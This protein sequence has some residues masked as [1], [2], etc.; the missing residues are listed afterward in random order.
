[1]TTLQADLTSV[2]ALPPSLSPDEIAN[3]IN[4]MRRWAPFDGLG[5]DH[6]QWLA[7]RMEEVRHAPGSLLLQPGEQ[8]LHLHFICH[9]NLRIE[10]MGTSRH[11]KVLAELGEGGCFPI[12]ALYEQRPVF[13]IFRAVDDLVTWTITDADFQQMQSASPHFALFCEGRSATLLEQSRQLYQSQFD[14]NRADRQSLDS[15]LAAIVERDPATCA[16][17]TPLH[18]VVQALDERGIGTMVVLDGD[19]RPVGVYTLRRLVEHMAR[20]HY[21][22]GEPVSAV[23]NPTPVVLPA[24]ALGHEAAMAM[25]SNAVR[26]VLAIDELGHLVGIIH[27][28]DLFGLQ[29]VGLSQISESIHRRTDVAALVGCAADIRQLGHNLIDQGVGA[30]QLTQLI[31]AL[32]D[33]L[34]QRIIDL[35]LRASGAELAGID[36]CWLAFGSEGRH[37]QTLSTDQDNG[38]LF[39]VPAGETADSVRSRLLPWARRVNVALDQCGF[40]LCKGNIMASNPECCLSDEE[41]RGRFR[42]WIGTPNPQALLNATIFFDFRPLHG[43]LPL[44]LSLRDWLTGAARGSSRLHMLLAESALERSPPLGLIRDFV[45]DDK[46]CIDLKLSGVTLF[47]DIAR[48]MALS[49]GIGESSTRNRLRQAGAARKVAK[50]EIDAWVNAF[51]FLQLIRLRNQHEQHVHGEEPSNL[52]NPAKLDAIDRKILVESLRNAGKLQKRAQGWVGAKAGAM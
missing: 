48:I 49:S 15:P 38:I 9:G 32:N 5:D 21:D 26:H 16:P 44:A 6:L 12:E 47:V 52:V 41:W 46:G 35:E 20:G 17:E 7:E 42:T 25:A 30:E 14:Y 27:E 24:N 50:A 2:A 1:M 40:T 28:R 8:P 18:T 22:P 23:M 11:N 37:E 33:Q 45:T 10:A 36:F 31:S 51:Q 34:T 39:S 13:S 19:R 43:A 29:R 4:L 3:R